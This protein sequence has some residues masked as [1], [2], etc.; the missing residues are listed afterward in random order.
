MRKVVEHLR[1]ICQKRTKWYFFTDNWF[2]FFK[3][4]RK[5]ELCIT[6]F[7][8]IVQVILIK[9][10]C[11]VFFL[12]CTEVLIKISSCNPI[13]DDTWVFDIKN[14]GHIRQYTQW[15][16]LFFENFPFLKHIVYFRQF[17]SCWK[18]EFLSTKL[19]R[20]KSPDISELSLTVLE[21]IFGP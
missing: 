12:N 3:N 2:P 9:R 14:L 15:S 21:E 18:N 7:S 5:T 1:V 16:I 19:G 4:F 13:P 17:E 10:V 20:R 11:Y 6:F 8:E